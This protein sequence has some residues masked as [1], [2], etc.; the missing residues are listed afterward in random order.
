VAVTSPP[1]PAPG[2]VSALGDPASFRPRP[3]FCPCVL[4]FVPDE[5]LQID[6]LEDDWK[7]TRVY[8]KRTTLRENDL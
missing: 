2:R 1:Y 3:S 4:V 7:R 6:I 5:C 8:L